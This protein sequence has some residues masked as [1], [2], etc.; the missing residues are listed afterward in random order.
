M[1][2]LA[3]RLSAVV[4]PFLLAG[5]AMAASPALQ[6]NAITARQAGSPQHLALFIRGGCPYNL[7][8][9]CHRARNGKMIC[10]CQS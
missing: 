1:T 7:D 6:D 2:R 10:H 3:S 9:V 4:I 5:T 8:K